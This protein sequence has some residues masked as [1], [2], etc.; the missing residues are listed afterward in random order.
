MMLYIVNYLITANQNY[1]VVS[2]HTSQNSHHQKVYKQYILERKGME[3]RE[4]S[5]SVFGKINC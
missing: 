5:Y 1:K 3:K 4:P 2:P